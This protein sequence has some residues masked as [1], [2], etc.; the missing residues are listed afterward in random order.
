MVV[1]LWLDNDVE[2]QEFKEQSILSRDQ[3]IIRKYEFK[4]YVFDADIKYK[5]TIGLHSSFCLRLD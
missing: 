3:T 2:R 4:K 5:L 1:M